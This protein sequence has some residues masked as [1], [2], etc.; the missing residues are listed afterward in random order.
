MADTGWLYPA[1]GENAWGSLPTGMSWTNANYI[2]ADDSN[3]ASIQHN[4]EY[5]DKTY[6]I[7]F[8]F[9]LSSTI[10]VGATISGIE[11]VINRYHPTADTCTDSRVSLGM[12]TRTWVPEVGKWNY[13]FTVAGDNKASASYWETSLADKTY[14]GSSDLW[15]T[16]YTRNDIVG[17]D[18]PFLGVILQA[19]FTTESAYVDYF[20]IKVYYTEEES[21]PTIVPQM[22]VGM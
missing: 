4:K 5:P 20:K 11:V 10:P 14:G 12:I 16:G 9:D 18:Y 21:E 22:I 7:G 19:A 15:N 1:Q 8:N 17:T 2:I 3:Y 6:L 13:T